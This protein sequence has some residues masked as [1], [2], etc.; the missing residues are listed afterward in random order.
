MNAF[1][2]SFTCLALGVLGHSFHRVI[3]T[4]MHDALSLFSLQIERR[5]VPQP[6]VLRPPRDGKDDVRQEAG[7]A[8]RDGLRHPDGR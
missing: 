6:A 4:Q 3:N 1:C 2:S 7:H 5:D 8:L